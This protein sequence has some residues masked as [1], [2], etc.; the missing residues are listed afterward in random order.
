MRSPSGA[1]IVPANFS[2]SNSG[3]RYHGSSFPAEVSPAQCMVNFVLPD[4]QTWSRAEVSGSSCAGFSAVL[5]LLCPRR[6]APRRQPRR[7]RRERN[8]T[9]ASGVTAEE[10]LSAGGALVLGQEA[11]DTANSVAFAALCSELCSKLCNQ[12]ST[13]SCAA[14]CVASSPRKQIWFTYLCNHVCNEFCTWLRNWQPSILLEWLSPPRQG[15]LLELR[16]RALFQRVRL[17]SSSGYHIVWISFSFW[18]LSS[19]GFSHR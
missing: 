17:L 12:R 2:T 10:K 8:R 5:R 18:H 6:P 3:S 15:D 1:V 14:S 7:M 13:A 4:V 16:M 9:V 11:L 19:F